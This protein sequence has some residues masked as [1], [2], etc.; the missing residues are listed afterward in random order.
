[1]NTPSE[2]QRQIIE[3]SIELIAQKGIQGLT[4]KNISKMIDVT[5]PAIYRHFA[6]KTDIL[7]A[8]LDQFN[9]LKNEVSGSVLTAQLR[10]DEKIERV[11]T[12]FLT[13]FEA[14][15]S[16]VSVV[17]SDEIFKNDA[18]LSARISEIIGGNERMFQ[19]VIQ[20]GQTVGEIRSD[21][22]ANYLV[23]IIMGSLRLLVKKW[24]LSNYNFP[25]RQEG[26]RLLAALRLV[27]L[28]N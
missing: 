16:L 19:M 1:M 9:Q 27:I 5:E 7:L 10:A 21:I 22:D 8:I 14:R 13:R 24:E 11:F 15:P 28:P 2:R 12:T 17:F 26:L 4:I 25:L 6:S 20:A 18:Q 23:M 3:A